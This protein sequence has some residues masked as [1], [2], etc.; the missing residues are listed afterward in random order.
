MIDDGDDDH[1][2]DCRDDV[3]IAIELAR[4]DH[5]LKTWSEIYFG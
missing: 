5:T 2:G 3:D 1:D 4:T